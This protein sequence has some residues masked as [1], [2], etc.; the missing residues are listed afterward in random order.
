MRLCCCDL[1]AVIL[2]FC[3]VWNMK[4]ELHVNIK[5]IL[6]LYI[7]IHMYES[8]SRAIKFVLIIACRV[9]VVVGH[10]VVV[11]CRFCNVVDIARCCRNFEF[12]LWYFIFCRWARRLRLRICLHRIIS[13][14]HRLATASLA[15]LHRHPRY[16]LCS[17]IVV[18]DRCSLVRRLPFERDT[19]RSMQ[20]FAYV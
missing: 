17:R 3:D 14:L 19:V 2:Y 20:I 1:W 4:Y 5:L 7:Y 8:Y 15:W 16:N 6:L 9:A 18:V 10:H 11:F 12:S 13:P